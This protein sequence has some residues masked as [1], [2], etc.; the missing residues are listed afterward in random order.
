MKHPAVKFALQSVY[1]LSMINLAAKVGV[2]PI[3]VG[4][5]DVR[6]ISV[7]D[8]HHAPRP[9]SIELIVNDQPAAE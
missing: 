3:E 4:A 1:E 8:T 7:T 5:A 2:I 6:R 9:H